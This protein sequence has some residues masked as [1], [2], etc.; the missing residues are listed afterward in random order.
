M[1]TVSD[2]NRSC[3]IENLLPT[4]QSRTTARGEGHFGRTDCGLF[5]LGIRCSMNCLLG[6]RPFRAV[7]NE[8]LWQEHL[9]CRTSDH[10]G[11]LH[12][13]FDVELSELCMRRLASGF[14][15][16]YDLRSRHGHDLIRLG[17]IAR[18]RPDHGMDSPL[19]LPAGAVYS[20]GS[21]RV[22]TRMHPLIP[23][24]RAVRAMEN[25]Q[26]FFLKLGAEGR[27]TRKASPRIIPSTLRCES[28]PDQPRFFRRR[29][30]LR[31]SESSVS[32]SV[33]SGRDWLPFGSMKR[34]R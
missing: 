20:A 32:T 17:R 11:Q 19:S 6:T 3:G 30:A 5:A 4:V 27:E 29:A 9:T 13:A 1:T 33:G 24:A 16:G 8:Q 15:I 23:K 28:N 21:R 14:R 18:P 22:A 12:R 25:D 31:A 7:S 10:C 34:F 2:S 26:S